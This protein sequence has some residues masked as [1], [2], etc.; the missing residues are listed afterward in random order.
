[1]KINQ[2]VLASKSSFR[3]A[4][5]RQTGLA[6]DQADAQVDEAAI[7]ANDPSQLALKRAEAK[8]VQVQVQDAARQGQACV[9]IGADQVLELAGQ[10]YGKVATPEQAKTRLA[11]FS[12]S[13]HQLHS[14]F[15]LS[16]HIAGQTPRLLSSRVVTAHMHMRRLTDA[17]IDVYVRTG[18]WQGCAGCYQYENRGRHLFNRVEGDEATIIGLPLLQLLHDLRSCGINGL[19]EPQ[20]PWQLL[21]SSAS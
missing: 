1:V 7:Q 12:G 19:R 10:A 2:L 16:L 3:V 20:G 13:I 14:A 15:A 17:D 11:A 6:F 5:L 9:V 21:Q 4:L 18:E 8:S